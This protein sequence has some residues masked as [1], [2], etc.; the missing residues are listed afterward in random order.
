MRP[1]D[2][3]VMI[4]VSSSNQASERFNLGHFEDFTN[5]I[6][7]EEVCSMLV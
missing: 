7:V 1:I 3:L 6:P 5:K 2:Q 4:L